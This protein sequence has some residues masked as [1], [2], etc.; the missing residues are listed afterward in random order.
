VSRP[1]DDRLSAIEDE[2]VEHEYVEHQDL[3]STPLLPPM[4]ADYFNDSNDAIQSPLQSPTIAAPSTMQSPAHT[5]ASTPVISGFLTPPLST[6]GSF[7]SLGRLRSNSGLQ[8]QSDIPN[9]TIAEEETDPWAIKLGHAN[10]HIFPEPYLPQ[11]CDTQTC[12]RLRD[13]WEAA[14]VQYMR[15]AAQTSEHYGVTS[16]IYKLTEQKWAEIDAVWRANFEMANAE[17]QANGDSPIFQPLAETEALSKVPS[18][19]DPQQP[20]KF[21][22][23]DPET[24]VGPMVRYAK[25]QQQQPASK[26]RPSFLRIFTDPASMLSNLSARR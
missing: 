16:H 15:Q 5:P 8:S 3:A 7:A 4:L 19:R 17:A 21:P 10:Y 9:S 25:I 18:L 12:R 14:R 2:Y 24:I 23:V 1:A 26:K 11:V 6:R 13:D 22:V 20:S